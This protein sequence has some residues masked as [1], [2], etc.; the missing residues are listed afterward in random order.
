MLGVRVQDAFAS[1]GAS[2]G[3]ATYMCRAYQVLEKELKPQRLPR[4]AAFSARRRATTAEGAVAE[5]EP[6]LGPGKGA[7][8]RWSECGLAGA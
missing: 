2:A 1:W 3:G 6:W 7:D 5:A 8:G 4:A